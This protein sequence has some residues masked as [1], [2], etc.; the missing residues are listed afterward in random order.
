MTVFDEIAEKAGDDQWEKWKKQVLEAKNEIASFVADRRGAKAK[1]VVDWFEG[2]F[3][4]CLQVTF[5]DGGL[6]A[7]I[8]FPKPGHTTFREEKVVNEVQIIKFLHEHTTIPVPRLISWGLTEDSPQHFGPFIISDFIKGVHLSDILRD[9]TD[10]KSLY[11]NPKIDERTLDIVFDQIADF[12]LQLFQFNFSRI[13]AISKDSTLNTWSVTGRPLTYSINELATTTFY[14]VGEFPTAAFESASDYFKYLIH[15]HMTHLWTQRNLS[16]DPK[17]AQERYIARHLFAKLVDKYCI[18]D[19]GPFKLFCDDLR[20]QNM[21]VDPKT[22]RIIAVFDL[23]FM[24]AMPGQYPSEPPW[25]LLLAGPDSYLF[26][27]RTM[28]EF[29]IA[30]EPRLEQFLQAMRRAERARKKLHDNKPL[31]DLMRESWL[32]KRFWFNYAARK[33]F[34]VEVIF[35]NCLNG[36]ADIESLEDEEVREGLEPFVKMKMEQLRAYDEDCKKFI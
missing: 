27:G 21:L 16:T 12:M 25:W 23:E 8:R 15:E 29:L 19:C 31:S 6:D 17:N 9:P 32:T 22:L 7:I 30:Y 36:R 28:E 3:N 33:P 24:N 34:D 10:Q 11:L 26:R 35:Y 14:P 2:S 18:D 4:F 13:G 20:P 5:N 1:E